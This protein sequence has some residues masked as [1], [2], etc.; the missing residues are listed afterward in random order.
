MAGTT[1]YSYNYQ[2]Q[3]ELISKTIEKIIIKI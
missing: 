1:F 3:I 2:F